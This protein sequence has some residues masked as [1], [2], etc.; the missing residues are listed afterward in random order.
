MKIQ[1]AD[2]SKGKVS[3]LVLRVSLPM[4]LAEAVNLLYSMV[5][6]I[7]IGHIRGA[8]SVALTGLGLCFPII[9]LISAFARL[10]G[11]NGGA[12]LCGMALGKGDKEE[13]ASVMGNSFIMSVL[14]GVALMLVVLIFNKPIL[15]AFGASDITY[16][17]ARDYLMI[18]ALGSVPVLITLGMNAFINAQG[19]ATI[20]MLTV[21]IGAITNIILDPILIYSLDMGVKGAATATVISQLLSCLFVIRFLTGK[22]A[23]LKLSFKYFKLVKERCL[24][25]IALGTSGFTM[26]ATN[27]VVQLVCNRCA[28]I[29]GGDLY[30]GVMTI[31]NSVRE[32]FS[33]PVNG[34]GSGASPVM[35]FNYGAK[36]GERTRKASNFMLYACLCISG[37]VWLLVFVFPE[38]ITMLFTQDSELIKATIPSLKIYFF[39]FIFM[40]F[41]TAGQQTFVAL[42]KAK[43]AVFFS[44]FRKVVIVV[45]LTIILPFF[46]GV[47]GVML[48]E[49]ISNLIGGLAAY[50]TMRHIVMKELKSL[51]KGK[52]EGEEEALTTT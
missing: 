29:W 11:F 14:T 17:F 49:P 12:P 40:S 28:F 18:Y 36:D 23:T 7:Y 24:R 5:D 4:I 9:S 51:S 30:V 22:N 26:G 41:Q 32:I 52:R 16:P 2:F 6:R 34:L 42:G 46:F 21:I 13:A 10:Y 15:Y 8:G 48:A 44:L 19:F 38:A 31:L 1:Q 37:I 27:S 33:T 50:T 43:P 47:N 20:G 3:T 35:S 25:I 45:P 39:G